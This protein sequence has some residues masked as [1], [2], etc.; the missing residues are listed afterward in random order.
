MGADNDGR[1]GRLLDRLA[2]EDLSAEEA[3]R[4]QQKVEYL[5]GLADSAA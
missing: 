1:I 5:Q 3:L 2:N 4:I